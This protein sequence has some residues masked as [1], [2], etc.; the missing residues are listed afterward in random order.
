MTLPSSRRG[1]AE[2]P[3]FSPKTETIRITR[4]TDPAEYDLA[5]DTQIEGWGIPYNPDSPIKKL[6][7]SWRAAP[8]HHMYLAYLGNEPAAHAMLY[9]DGRV[10]YLENASTPA[11]FRNRGLH[12]ALIERRIH[13]AQT[14]FGCD[15]I[16]GAADFESPS[17]INQLRCGLALSYLAA[18]WTASPTP[19]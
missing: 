17:R 7:R 9:I 4:V 1:R 18:N 5:L 10:G 14:L 15:T 16:L 11:R 12:T 6:R 19:Q 13:D 8:G 2:G 3:P